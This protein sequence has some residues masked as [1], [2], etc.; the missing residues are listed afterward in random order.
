MKKMLIFAAIFVFGAVSMVSAQDLQG[1]FN[2]S[3][4]VGIGIPMGDLADDDPENADGLYRSIGFKFGASAEY[5]FTPAIGAGLEFLYAIHGAKD[6]DG[7]EPG[8]KLHTMNIGAHFKYMFMP[9]SMLRPYIL[10]GVGL[11][12]NKLKDLEFEVEE[13]VFVT[14]DLDLDTKMYFVGG[15]GV[16]YW[17][18]EMISIF[19][20]AGFD[21]LLLDGAGAEFDGEPVIDPDTGEEAELQ[22]N[23]YFLDF[24]AGINVWF[25]GTE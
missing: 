2:I 13:G 10:A 20:E 3:P 9:E 8:D 18:S 24:K 1:M 23:Y 12:M 16:K 4:Y 14:G 11:T 22:T 6:F 7:F 5:F 17:V 15:F 21:Y 19:G 25:G